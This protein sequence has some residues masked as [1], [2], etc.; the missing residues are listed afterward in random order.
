MPFVIKLFLI[1]LILT[2]CSL[3][4]TQFNIPIAD[5]NRTQIIEILYKGEPVILRPYNVAES[6]ARGAI[7]GGYHDCMIWLCIP[8]LATVGSIVGLTSAEPPSTVEHARKALES[9]EVENQFDD[10]L[11]KQIIVTGGELTPHHFVVAGHVDP[12]HKREDRNPIELTVRAQSIGI[13]PVAGKYVFSLI[14]Q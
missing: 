6:I 5:D 2:G 12:Y 14:I 10:L 4:T 13:K 7:G 8:I 9:A 3:V 1:A 11:I